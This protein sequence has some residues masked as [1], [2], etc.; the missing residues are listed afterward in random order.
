M[1]RLWT[2]F[3]IL[4][5]CTFTSCVTDSSDS[6][7]NTTSDSNTTTTTTNTDTKASG[8]GISYSNRK[9]NQRS[10][11]GV[12][13]IRIDFPLFENHHNEKVQQKVN[14]RISAFLDKLIRKFKIKA[15]GLE[16]VGHSMLTVGYT[17]EEVDKDRVIVSL[18]I[19]EQYP[20]GQKANL[21]SEKM[22]FDL[23]VLEKTLDN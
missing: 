1:Q 21:S 8:E 15:L 2:T 5:I 10:E 12:Y 19:N 18:S 7:S 11:K 16:T 9:K 13:D 6:T 4:A 3:L 22:E 17:V 23:N 14:N 20:D